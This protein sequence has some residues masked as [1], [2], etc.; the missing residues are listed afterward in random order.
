MSKEWQSQRERGHPFFLGLLTWIALKLGRQL[1]RL[2]LYPIIFYYFL[3]ARTARRASQQFLTRALTRSPKWWEIYRHLFTFA[4][5]SIDRLCFIAGQEKK[6]NVQV[7]GNEIFNHYK[8]KGCFL[9]TAHLGSFDVL[10]IMGM[11]ARADALPIKILLDVNHNSMVLQLLKKLDP[12]LFPAII[13]A[14]LPAPQLALTL[15]EAIQ[16]KQLIG[17][18]ADRCAQGERTEV[19]DFLGT[20]AQFPLGIWQMASL[21]KVPVIACFGI[22]SGENNY[23]LYIELISDQIGSNRHDRNVAITTA[24]SNYAQHLESLVKQ[25]PYNWFNFYDFWQDESY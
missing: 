18:M 17:I 3:T 6:F 20:P 8:N 1:L 23:S 2:C 4:L 22:Y 16:K 14:Q 24:I 5:V 13:D 9:V 12:V 25:Y 7:Y 21:L 11:G 15:E 10:R 19:V